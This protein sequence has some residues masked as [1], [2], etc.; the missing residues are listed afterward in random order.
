MKH[1]ILLYT[2]LIL[3]ILLLG[4]VLGWKSGEMVTT[5]QYEQ[6]QADN[7][8]KFYDCD[9][10]LDYWELKIKKEGLKDD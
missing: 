7:W 9:S 1:R 10:Q 3:A 8:I 5:Y 4:Y 2:F 6:H